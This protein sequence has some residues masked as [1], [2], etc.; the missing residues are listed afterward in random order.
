MTPAAQ[1]E[2]NPGGDRKRKREHDF[3]GHC[4]AVVLGDA[5][6]YVELKCDKCGGNSGR[7]TKKYLSGIR[8]F[9]KHYQAAHKETLSPAQILSRCSVRRVEM[10][11]V[12]EIESG[13]VKK[14]RKVPVAANEGI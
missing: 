13:T 2:V 14:V 5:G 10:N 4:G 12:R 7:I 3:S 6:Y 9:S 1:N 11:E 8:G